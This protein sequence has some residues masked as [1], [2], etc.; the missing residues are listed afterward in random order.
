MVRPDDNNN[1]VLTKGSPHGSIACVPLG[2]H[3]QPIKTDGAK[4]K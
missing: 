4:L 1:K 2:G 3:T